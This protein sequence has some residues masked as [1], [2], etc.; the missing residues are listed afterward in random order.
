MARDG[1]GVSLARFGFGFFYFFI[2][3]D[4]DSDPKGLKFFRP[5]PSESDG[6]RILNGSKIKYL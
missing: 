3:L 5:K 4:L 2:D 6:P 1:H